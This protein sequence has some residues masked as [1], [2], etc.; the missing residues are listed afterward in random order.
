M[1]IGPG[2]RSLVLRRMALTAP[3]ALG[4]QS[5][6]M[7]AASLNATTGESVECDWKYPQNDDSSPE[8][9]LAEWSV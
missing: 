5:R 9:H 7:V 1:P 6:P 8:C 4:N 3:K 2:D